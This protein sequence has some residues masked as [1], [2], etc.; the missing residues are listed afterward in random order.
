MEHRLHLAW[1]L[2]TWLP[3]RIC[4]AVCQA[5]PSRARLGCRGSRVAA[6]GERAGGLPI[7]GQCHPW[8]VDCELIEDTL[9]RISDGNDARARRLFSRWI[10][11]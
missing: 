1:K 8:M 3:R 7:V 5:W 6:A 4:P 11:A 10:Y 9:T 2:G